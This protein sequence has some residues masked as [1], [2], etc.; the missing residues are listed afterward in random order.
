M[1]KLISI[2]KNNI[3]HLIVVVLLF[4]IVYIVSQ[5]FYGIYEDIAVSTVKD[6]KQKIADIE[7]TLNI[8]NRQAA[9]IKYTKTKPLDCKN[10]YF[11][12]GYQT[13][14]EKE[15]NWFSNLTKDSKPYM[16]VCHNLQKG[17]GEVGRI[18]VQNIPTKASCDKV[19]AGNFR[20]L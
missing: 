8:C 5:F 18:E 12:I 17:N 19:Y 9:K 3:K 20:T 11:V 13:G 14:K 10:S 4:C 16:I 1:K 6:N 15:S 2:V 7:Q